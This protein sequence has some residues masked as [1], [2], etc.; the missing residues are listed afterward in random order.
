M[1]LATRELIE[2]LR[3]M[4]PGDTISYADLTALAG[5]DVQERRDLLDTARTY[6]REQ[7]NQVFDV[8]T[9]VGLVCLSEA[10]KIGL[11]RKRRTFT[12]HYTTKTTRILQTVDLPQLSPVEKQCWLAEVSIS[13]AVSMATHEQTARQIE[14]Q[15][16]PRRLLIDPATYKELF[17]GL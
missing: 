5:V 6:L 8:L 12:H 11:G 3:P 9:N 4:Q 7:H 16:E 1:S 10:G 14:T 17:K 15:R 13:A 2:R